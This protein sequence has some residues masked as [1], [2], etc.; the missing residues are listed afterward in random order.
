MERASISLSSSMLSCLTALNGIKGFSQFCQYLFYFFWMILQKI[1]HIRNLKLFYFYI[2]DSSSPAFL[3]FVSEEIQLQSFCDDS[4]QIEALEKALKNNTI[5]FLETGSGKTLIA[6]M[7]LR[8]HA[9]LLRKPSRSIA[10]FLVPKV[11]LVSQVC[12]PSSLL[13]SYI[14]LMQV[15]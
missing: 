9:H 8:S 5:V 4:Y 15:L 11:V 12:Q 6:I 10:V 7:L 14:C 1:S 3:C 13:Q 2:V